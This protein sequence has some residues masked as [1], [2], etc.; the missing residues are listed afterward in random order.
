M[1]WSNFACSTSFHLKMTLSSHLA[2]NLTKKT[3][4]SLTCSSIISF[5]FVP[6][7]N[8]THFVAK[9]LA[10]CAPGIVHTF[11][12]DLVP[13]SNWIRYTLGIASKCRCSMFWVSTCIVRFSHGLMRR[14]VTRNSSHG[15]LPPKINGCFRSMKRCSSHSQ[16]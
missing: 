3:Q 9:R 16:C 8:P 5:L 14:G 12:L 10:I 2:I 15:V 1:V 6:S 13:A 4:H 7:P 11:I